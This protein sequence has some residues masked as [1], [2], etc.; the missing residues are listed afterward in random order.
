LRTL[1]TTS[2]AFI[3]NKF[4]FTSHLLYISIFQGHTTAQLNLITL[5]SK[6]RNR[7]AKMAALKVGDSLPDDVVFSYIPYTEESSEITACGIPINYNASKGLFPF[8]PFSFLAPS[9]LPSKTPLNLSLNHPTS[10]H[11]PQEPN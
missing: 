7:K 9:P 1:I 2:I 3:Y 5:P 4:S 11:F 10:P 6:E 8:F